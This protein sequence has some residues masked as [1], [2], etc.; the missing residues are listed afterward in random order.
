MMM[1]RELKVLILGEVP[2]VSDIFERELFEQEL[3]SSPIHIEEHTEFDAEI[4]R[5]EN[6][7]LVLIGV[8]PTQARMPVAPGN[9]VVL[10]VIY[11]GQPLDEW[12]RARIFDPFFTERRADRHSGLEL[13]TVKSVVE[14]GGGRMVV[15]K[16]DEQTVTC[17]YHPALDPSHE[18]P[19]EPA[20]DQPEEQVGREP[21]N[22][23]GGR[24]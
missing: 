19:R 10:E 20:R 6:Y 4:E 2:E 3:P 22:Q 13:A 21:R 18:Q 9:Y 5:E 8:T 23:R 1:T 16:R 15:D 12:M 11:D 24:E 7:D 14:Q 17:I